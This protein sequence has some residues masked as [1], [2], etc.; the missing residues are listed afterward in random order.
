MGVVETQA[1]EFSIVP[2]ELD[3]LTNTR[4]SLHLF[5]FVAE[6]PLVTAQ[7][8]RF[9]FPLEDDLLSQSCLPWF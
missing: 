9:L 7:D 1:K 2:R 3:K 6:N 4:R 5:H 8:P